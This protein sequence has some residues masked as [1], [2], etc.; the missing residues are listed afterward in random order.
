M[1]KTKN[2][3]AK[4]G[5]LSCIVYSLKTTWK[6]S[7]SIA[8][9]AVLSVP[10]NIIL[11][12][13]GL[14]LPSIII[15]T[16]EL[17]NDFIRI[18]F[19]ILGILTS[20]F[21]FTLIGNYIDVKKRY[22][23]HYV[24]FEMYA[25]MKKRE[26]DMDRYLELDEQNKK[27]ISRANEISGNNHSVGVHFISH[28]ARMLQNILN[29]ILF[30]TVISMLHPVILI[31]LIIGCL[32]NYFVAKWQNKK[33]WRKSDIHMQVNKK[34]NYFSW[35]VAGNHEYGKDIRLFNFSSFFD[36][37]INGLQKQWYDEE[38]NMDNNNFIKNLTDFVI[39]LKTFG[40]VCGLEGI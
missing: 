10:I 35:T 22:S 6:A 14:Y 3:K 31:L 17:E 37:L 34:I 21:I 8:V 30:G 38:R 4:Y 32:I 25:E 7:K 27:I 29:F 18:L 16:L 24:C 9:A 12:A 15:E 11:N 5:V 28:F 2:R 40:A 36:K 1:K 33:L 20:Q 19:L 39:L 13:I 23:E 26:R